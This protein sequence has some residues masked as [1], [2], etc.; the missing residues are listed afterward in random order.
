MDFPREIEIH[1]SGTHVNVRFGEIC[2]SQF[3]MTHTEGHGELLA[4]D[5]R[6][7]RST[8]TLHHLASLSRTCAGLVWKIL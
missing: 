4:G 2:I 3:F 8:V 1:P 5:S 6:D 7:C